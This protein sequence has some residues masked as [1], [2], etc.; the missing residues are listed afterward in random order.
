VHIWIVSLSLGLLLSGHWRLEGSQGMGIPRG[1]WISGIVLA[2]CLVLLA[3]VAGYF[4][5]N[6]A[7]HLERPQARSTVP[8]EELALEEAALESASSAEGDLPG[9]QIVDRVEIARYPTVETQERVISGQEF[10]V[11]V[12][13]TET[14]ITADVTIAQGEMT[15]AGRLA[16][17]LP[18]LDRWEIEVALSAEGFQFRDNRNTGT[19]FLRQEG[20]STPALF[21]LTAQPIGDTQL[22]RKLYATFWHQGAYLAKVQREILVIQPSAAA[23]SG[24]QTAASVTTIS[25]GQPPNLSPYK[26]S[27]PPDLTVYVVTARG[28]SLP[29]NSWITVSS[30]FLQ[31][32]LDTFSTP[33][34]M[35]SWISSH[36]LKIS[37]AGRGL[38]F[39]ATSEADPAPAA[40][41]RARRLALLQGLGKEL[42]QRFA[43]PAFKNAFWALK[44]KLG[45]EFDSIQIFTND[46]TL[47][48]ELMRPV[49]SDGSDEQDFLGITFRIARW[50]VS[51]GM[52]PVESPPIEIPVE[53]LY[54]ISP[55]YTADMALPGVTTELE[56][57]RQLPGFQH[58]E[59]RFDAL[60]ALFAGADIKPGIVH[61]AGHGTAKE[62]VPGIRDYVMHLEDGSLDVTS[63]RGLLSGRRLSKGEAYPLFFFNACDLGQASHVANFVDGWAPAVLESGAG[64]YIGGLWPVSDHGAATFAIRFYG[65]LS[66]NLDEGSAN[67]AE[68]LRQTRA[69]VYDHGDPTFLAYVYYG[70]PDLRLVAP[71]TR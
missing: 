14:Q 5:Y 16:L 26:F 7:T 9:G 64:G 70:Y 41:D 39:S 17:S 4:F 65:L 52:M 57:L 43:P 67:V 31:L 54:V 25:R 66:E 29:Q 22:A 71:A 11:Q 50:H 12:S 47:P 32:N 61:Y 34:G 63:W 60:H 30:P 44:D 37:E 24:T 45:D 21:H 48:W 33:A 6:L 28:P 15:E 27:S 38:R 55:E 23:G 1:L 3:G 20:D 36:Y 56:A 18:D 8:P 69:K 68:M 59:G 46:P 42:Y 49:R 53:A 19:I 51:H 40:S 58:V 62:A 35:D 13:L 2:I 10:T